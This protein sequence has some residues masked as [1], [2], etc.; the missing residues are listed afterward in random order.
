MT[1]AATINKREQ[2]ID[3]GRRSLGDR[4]KA[5]IADV[6]A[7]NEQHRGRDIAGGL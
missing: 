6:V 3:P 5:W 7:K 2:T 1:M 4:I